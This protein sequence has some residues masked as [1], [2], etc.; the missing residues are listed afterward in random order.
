MLSTVDG[1]QG[2]END[3][4]I[5][6]TVRANSTGALGFLDDA[7][8]INMSLTRARHVP[9]IIGH[10][11]TLVTG[12]NQSGVWFELLNHL[13]ERRCV[14]HGFNGD[15]LKVP[16]TNGSRDAH[17]DHGKKKASVQLA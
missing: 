3:I 11:D 8:R 15:L 2:Q 4:I 12:S 13:L 9:F 14:R 16:T 10:Y 1:F 17:A 6:V 7:R 5:L